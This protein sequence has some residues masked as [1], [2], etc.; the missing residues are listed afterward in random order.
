MVETGTGEVERL[1]AAIRTDLGDDARWFRPDGYRSVA[2]C[3][4]DSIYSTGN[5][6]TGVVDAVN[7]YKERRA[8]E[9]ADGATDSAT[10]LLTAVA[11]WGGPDALAEATKRWRCWADRSAPYK[12]VAVVQAA[13]LLANANIETV[14]DVQ[15]ELTD[16]DAQTRSP[17]KGEWLALPGQRSGLTWTYFLMLCGVPGVKADRM[18]VRYVE[19]ALGR[20]VDPHEAALLVGEVADQRNLPRN[21]LD[22]AIWRQE[23]G[24]PIYI[25]GEELDETGHDA[26]Q[27]REDPQ[28]ADAGTELPFDAILRN[29]NINPADVLVI[30]HAF[31]L[32]HE[33]SGVPGIHADSTR[34]EILQYTSDQSANPRSFPTDP[35][36]LWVVTLRESGAHGEKGSRAR[37]WSVLENHGEI[38]TDGTRRTF[39]LTETEHLA[40]FRDR[41]VIGWPAPRAWRVNGQTAA[42][43]PIKEIA[44]ANP[45]PFPGFD[46]LALDRTQLLSV[47][48]EKKYASWRT[49][50]S[51]VV[52]IYLITDTRD[53]RQYVGKADGEETLRQRWEAYA[54][55]G[56]G[57]N[58]E[59]KGL[60]PA[61]FR[62][63]TLIVFDPA[64]PTREINAAESHF[65]HALDTRKHGLN[66]N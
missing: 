11:R 45:E 27:L 41:L 28:G 15:R 3:L 2:L 65:K 61:T 18:V 31:V 46:S 38:S 47:M 42:K 63:S 64:T 33:D 32:E 13:Q 50:L 30:R 6:Y 26:T 23:S 9:G 7:K 56:H 49:A 5:H 8:G 51:S 37:L 55:N 16:P 22:H 48:R 24:R 40:G 43:Y 62:Y 60:D 10:D 19:R 54:S 14:H 53:G 34:E 36:K 39:N 58:I 12:S 57:G 29:A 52:G 35:P 21:L 17:L 20:P 1:A 44:D 25:D 4:I 66:R 59:L